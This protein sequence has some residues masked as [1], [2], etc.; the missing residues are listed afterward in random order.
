[1][2]SVNHRASI[3]SA[4]RDKVLLLALLLLVPK[5]NHPAR[6]WMSNRRIQRPRY[7]V[8]LLPLAPEQEEQAHPVHY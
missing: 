5:R 8:S 3:W 1:M 6:R 4:Y 7:P 2:F